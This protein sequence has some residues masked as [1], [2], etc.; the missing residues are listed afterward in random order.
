MIDLMVQSDDDH[1]GMIA[2]TLHRRAVFDWQ[3]A[4]RARHGKAP[5]SEALEDFL[6][7]E[8]AERRVWDYRERA[9]LMLA[10]P[11][12]VTEFTDAAKATVSQAPKKQPLRTWFWPWGVATAFAIDTPEQSL[13][14]KGLFLRLAMLLAA[15]IV[16]SLLL[17][18]FVVQGV[19]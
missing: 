4:Y 6:L 8:R 15:V 17:R 18:V 2:F 12:D 19:N 10:T 9:N 11:T 1:E 16:T 14:W 5:A 7:G 13:N 3:D